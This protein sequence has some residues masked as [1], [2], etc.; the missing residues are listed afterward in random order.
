MARER[1]R[2]DY[3][4]TLLDLMQAG[5]LKASQQLHANHLGRRYNATLLHDGCLKLPRVSEPL[6]PSAAARRITGRET[7]GW[8]FWLAP[9][10]SGVAWSLKRLRGRALA[11]RPQAVDE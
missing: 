11:E 10:A 7:N 6:T 5:H 9:Q 4:V 3:N 2:R 1:E 8:A